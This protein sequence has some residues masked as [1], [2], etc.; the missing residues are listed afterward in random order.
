MKCTVDDG[1]DDEDD[2]D[3]YFNG[4]P[5]MLIEFSRDDWRTSRWCKSVLGTG[6]TRG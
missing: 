1:G 5:T 6:S 3:C 2:G 4:V